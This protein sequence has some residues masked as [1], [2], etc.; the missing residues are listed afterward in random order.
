MKALILS[1]GLGTRLRPFTERTPKPLFSINGS[2]LLDRIIHQLHQAG[3]KSIMVNTHHLHRDIEAYL[4]GHTYPIPVSTCYEPEIMGTGGAIRNLAAFWDVA[5]FMV[6]NCDILTDIDLRAVYDFH[7]SH[8]LPATLVL[9]NAPE[10]NTVSVDRN[11]RIS[12][13]DVK[14][15]GSDT[16]QPLTFTGIQVLDPEIIEWIPDKPF[17]HSIDVYRHLIAAKTPPMAYVATNNQWEDIGT[18]ERFRNAAMNETAP[19]AFNKA[20]GESPSAPIKSHHLAGDGS[21]RTW[22]RLETGGGTLIMADHGIRQD[23]SRTEIDAFIAIGSHLLTR[24]VRVPEI[25]G[26]DLFS[27]LA[28]LED[29]GDTHLQDFVLMTNDSDVLLCRYRSVIDQLVHMALAGRDGFDT[30][31]TYQSARY[32]RNLILEREC[33]YFVEAFLNGWLHLETRFEDLAPDFIHLANGAI[34]NAV[35]GF[36]H[37][38]FQS[39]NIMVR[40]GQCHFIDFQGGRIGPIQYDLASLLIDPYVQLSMP[41]Q[42]ALLEYGIHKISAATAIDP[43]RCR[44]GYRYCC[45]TRNLQMLGAFG[46]LSRAKGKPHFENYIPAAAVT[47]DH[48]LSLLENPPLDGLRQVA[49]II[50]KRLNLR[51]EHL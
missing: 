42:S 12:G 47:L 14:N 21:D 27:G 6:I 51:D 4:A 9:T 49:K 15:N 29:L 40:N 8:T 48:N 13:F 2:T 41:L 25:Y 22:Y 23:P 46:Y 28:Y 44:L 39:R 1:A 10:F 5:P 26:F 37:R 50:M 35:E 24:G 36:M 17:V 3:C 31:W 20:F 33:R 32:D 38:D 30:A 45:I 11:N 43:E 7:C 34:S 18:P 19:I 16:L